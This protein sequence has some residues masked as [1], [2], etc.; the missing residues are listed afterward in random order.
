MANAKQGDTV[1]VHYTGRLDD[2]SVFDSS[3]GRDPLEFTLGQGRVIP[4]FEKAVEGLAVGDST[5][6][7]IPTEEAYGPRS[8]QLVMDI[9]RSQLPDGMEPEVGQ[10]LEMRT[11]DGQAVPVKVTE[12]TEDT[13]QVDANHPLA[14][15]ALT[16]KLELVKIV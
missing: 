7:R 12:T 6:A 14:G 16:F 11:Q 1:H 8:D 4:G 10:H 5:E 2:G 9:P 15:E 3:E 13:V